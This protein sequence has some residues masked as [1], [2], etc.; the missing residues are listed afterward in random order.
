ME[1]LYNINDTPMA[2]RYYDLG[3]TDSNC[4]NIDVSKYEELLSRFN[5]F[6]FE[7]NKEF[8][9]SIKRILS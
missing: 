8:N 4:I 2:I 6:S 7:D 5:D 3:V 1:R 9:R